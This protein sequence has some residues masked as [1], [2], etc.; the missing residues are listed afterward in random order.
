[1]CILTSSKIQTMDP[2]SK[3]ALKP[4]RDMNNKHYPKKEVFIYE[5][6]EVTSISA[7]IN[8]VTCV[9]P[10]CS[11]AQQLAIICFFAET[12]VPF[13]YQLLVVEFS[14]SW[15][16]HYAQ[17]NRAFFQMV[18]SNLENLKYK[19][20]RCWILDFGFRH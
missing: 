3:L 6:G 11:A 19:A 13:Q 7:G 8:G 1:M 20:T 9:R 15:P 18:V 17:E 16:N 12:D 2:T 10:H 4:P 5:R 14:I